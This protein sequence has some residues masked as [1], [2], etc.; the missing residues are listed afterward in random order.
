[1]VLGANRKKQTVTMVRSKLRERIFFAALTVG[2]AGFVCLIASPHFVMDSWSRDRIQTIMS[3]WLT[4]PVH[5]GE[6]SWSLGLNGLILH[7]E[8][9]S[10]DE[11]DGKTTFLQS[12]QTE[13]G[14]ALLPM[15]QGKFYAHHIKLVDPQISAIHIS[16]KRWNFSDLPQAPGLKYLS[17]IEVSGGQVDITDQ[18]PR[19]A[20]WS[21]RHLEN[22]TMTVQ[23]P[24]ENSV[25]PFAI[26]A[27]MPSTTTA[28]PTAPGKTYVTK[29]NLSGI[30]SGALDDWVKNNHTFEAEV[31]DLNAEDVRMFSL[32]APTMRGF[33]DAKLKGN[34]IPQK[35]FH[36]NADIV[37]KKLRIVIPEVGDWKVVDGTS[38]AD[39]VID[40]QQIDYKNFSL[41]LP[42]VLVRSEGNIVDWRTRDPSYKIKFD[43]VA[44]DV[45]K[46]A[47]MV[48]ARILPRE[49]LGAHAAGELKRNEQ[50]TIAQALL[51]AKVGGAGIIKANFVGKGKDLTADISLRGDALKLHA[52]MKNGTTVHTVGKLDM[53][54][55]LV[56]VHH[57]KRKDTITGTA[58]VENGS[59]AID[60]GNKLAHGVSGNVTIRNTDLL[61]RDLKGKFGSG[62]FQLS[63]MLPEKPTG[64]VALHYVGNDINL[65]QAKRV[66]NAL[67]INAMPANDHNIAGTIKN[68]VVD[69]TGTLRNPAVVMTA[70]PHNVY[71][72]TG[73]LERALTVTGGI[74][75]YGEGAFRLEDVG[76]RLGRGT[77][78]INGSAT[79][80]GANNLT[81][82]GRDIDLSDVELAVRGLDIRPVALQP[83]VLF[84]TV[85]S[86]K[87]HVTGSAAN[88]QVELTTVPSHLYY[89]PKGF[90]RTFVL[91]GGN[92][93][94][95]KN[96][97][98]IHDLK[99][100]LGR[101]TFVLNGTAHL[102]GPDAAS[103]LKLAARNLDMS[104]VKM[105]LQ[106]LG[107]HHPLLAQQLLYGTADDVTLNLKGPNKTPEISLVAVPGNIH[108]EPL[109]GA[110]ALSLS[111]GKVT[112]QDDSLRLEKVRLHSQR[113]NAL[114]SLQLDSLSKASQLHLLD[115][116]AK[117]F[118]LG[119]LHSYLA[120]EHTP[121][122]VR[123]TYHKLIQQYGL[124]RP[125]GT[126]TGVFHMD[127][128][129]DNPQVTG[130][131]NLTRFGL[132][133]Y[134][135]PI[136]HVTG[137]LV[138]DG[139][140]IH[141][142]NIQG[143]IGSSKFA[144][145]GK[146]ANAAT[147]DATWDA[148]LNMQVNMQNFLTL[149]STVDPS[150]QN[151][152][153]ASA[154][155]PLHMKVSGDLT[156]MTTGQFKSAIPPETII[157]LGGPFG[158]I[159]KPAG[160]P[161]TLEGALA[162]GG[163]GPPR[164]QVTESKVT[165]GDT[166]VGWTG[167][168]IVSDTKAPRLHFS[169]ELPNPLSISQLVGLLPSGNRLKDILKDASGTAKGK[170][171]FEGPTTGPAM[172]GYIDINEAN[173]P[174]LKI[175]GV[176]GRLQANDW[177]P[178][179]KVTAGESTNMPPA[180]SKLDISLSKARVADFAFENVAGTVF[181]EDTE[182]GPKLNIHDVTATVFGGNGSCEGW[183]MLEGR[184]PFSLLT[185][186]NQIN[187]DKMVTALLH[188]PGQMTGTIE[189]R[190]EID[191]YAVTGDDFLRNL[192]AVGAFTAHNGKVTRLKELQ[193]KLTQGNFLMQGL[194]GFDI[195]NLLAT[196]APVKSGSFDVFEGKFRLRNE[197]LHLAKV[198]FTGV[199]LRLRG[200]GNIDLSNNTIDMHV[201]GNIPR[202]AR[203]FLPGPLESIAS[204]LSPAT[205]LN[206]VAAH[207]QLD[208]PSLPLI[209]DTGDKKPRSF[210]F[211]VK[212]KL[213]KPDTIAKAI[214]ETFHFLP[215]QPAATAYPAIGISMSGQDT[216]QFKPERTTA[217]DT[218]TVPSAHETTM[219]IEP[220]SGSTHAPP[221]VNSLVV[222][223]QEA[224]SEE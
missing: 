3:Q 94:L 114:I 10:V 174:G 86:A 224:S 60:K 156:G 107:V 23:R 196:L 163:E 84:G 91:T 43:F 211:T 79:T 108:F 152:I 162:F 18:E 71:F 181:A 205:I 143:A 137:T 38:S 103:D 158:N 203:S 218:M 85:A 202:I 182:K 116:D 57:P 49:I 139:K 90:S 12:G 13:I 159:I 193:T 198:L 190:T 157:S 25:W 168:Y 129:G 21:G 197:K 119:D 200:E 120:A 173:L 102:S 124:S 164:I 97:A 2:A 110:R 4:R 183:I 11:K 121:P 48:P 219:V 128:R 134:Q 111:G 187:A 138:A 93:A 36:A 214:S 195:N 74:V 89:V 73:A 39:I 98:T 41:A 210:E 212:T 199:E 59:L 26:S 46:L 170:L 112:Y 144:V 148:D 140:D 117:P 47:D 58:T 213:D 40:E 189:G 68:A 101:G 176:T 53:Q 88:P 149:I 192:R 142:N 52:V 147:R 206:T 28:T 146:V 87:L 65:L 133:F 67:D 188:A 122:T 105:A 100:S 136:H 31:T 33:V 191:G 82:E 76:G 63:G 194:L 20:A 109:S 131:L 113:T 186:F 180:T 5:L 34:G 221:K 24:R 62:D 175:A 17:S 106:A 19:P 118:N 7:S 185:R 207:T 56:S 161:V 135:Y 215:P 172:R 44:S 61:L 223:Q 80:S 150:M 70:V 125:H 179:K 16:G 96:I 220:S 209:G 153:T 81:V 37:T 165:I 155:I 6:T 177:F 217:P 64:P 166:V 35:G 204:F 55:R 178:P 141:L 216:R 151:I 27:E 78:M 145:Q 30:G 66:L 69:V 99:G 50:L 201:A 22:V 171:E 184:R 54:A 42:T 95:K 72:Q 9:F 1:M 115:L 77:F 29:I 104:N 130:Q 45:S 83:Q 160:Q 32:T 51:P 222:E 208:F 14:L 75:R 15:A 123:D 167:E 8:S 127:A 169:L 126:M 154:P 92:V 132:R